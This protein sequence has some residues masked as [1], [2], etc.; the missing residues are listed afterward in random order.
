MPSRSQVLLALVAFLLLSTAAWHPAAAAVDLPDVP[1]EA[2]GSTAVHEGEAR[3]RARLVV[4]SESVES[5]E[6]VRAGVLF[7]ISP[8]WHVYWRNPGDSALPTRIAWQVPQ[9][10]DVRIGEIAWP[11]PEVFQEIGTGFTT[12]GYAKQV[13]LA[14]SIELRAPVDGPVDVTADVRFLVCEEICIP[15]RVSLQ[16]TLLLG[17]APE[18]DARLTALFDDYARRVPRVA[19]DHGVE[20]EALY[21]QD[22]VRPGDS[23]MLGIAAKG[24]DEGGVCD[25]ASLA[26]RDPSELFLPY[27][28]TNPRV[29]PLGAQDWPGVEGGVMVAV[30]GHIDVGAP[31][32]TIDPLRGLLALPNVGA[33]GGTGYVEVNLPFPTAPAD[34]DIELIATDWLDTELLDAPATVPGMHLPLAFAL[35][36]LGGL[37]LNLMPCVLPVLAIKLVALSEQVHAARAQGMRQGLAYLAGIEVSMALLAGFVIALREAGVAVGWGFQFQEPIYMAAIAVLVVAMACNLLGLFEMGWDLGRAS[38]LGQGGGDL[39]RSFFD[40]FLAVALSTPCSA[41][42]LG[43]AV[44]FA[45]AG[46]AFDIATIFA[47]IGLGLALPFVAASFVPGLARVIPAPGPWMTKLRAVLGLALLATAAWLLWLLDRAAGTEAQLWV[48]ALLVAV[49]LASF[50][51]G[52]RQRHAPGEPQRLALGAGLLAVVLALAVLPLDPLPRDARA[53]DG[54]SSIPWQE[55]SPEAVTATLAEGQP[56]FVY[57][58]ADWCITCKVNEQ[59]VLEDEAVVEAFAHHHIATFRADWTLRDEQIR[60]ELARHGK[61]GVPV[62]LVYDPTRAERPLILPELLT[63]DAVLKALERAARA[64]AG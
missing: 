46:T 43:T 17:A 39:R 54:D 56:V 47:A 34:A 8:G 35:A 60:S 33:D 12:F 20:V 11:A 45:F 40:G 18:P 62:Y 27:S 50:A 57:F 61:A 1:P 44:G 23:F 48:V 38:M 59:L 14:Q 25:R 42:F 15:G 55:F 51:F 13:L 24:C 31:A 4:E 36:L 7:D 16:R 49:A 29:R 10:P 58:T 53:N 32:R 2:S 6:P 26:G 28:A 19:A 9:D 63:V 52:R 41:P 37:I 3:V 5:G 30:R 64:Q 21:S 22:A